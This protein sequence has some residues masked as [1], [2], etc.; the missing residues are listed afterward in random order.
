MGETENQPLQLSFHACLKV[1]F[2]G[3]RVT[4][5]GGLILIGE[6]D[7]RWGL[8]TLLEEPWSDSR[9]G[10]HKQCTRAALLRQPVYS[11]LAG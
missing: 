4:S 2:Q 8:E 11:R 7:E 5:D 9:Q 6:W 3:S 1:D 10:L